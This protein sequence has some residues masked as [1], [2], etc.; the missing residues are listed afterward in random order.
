MVSFNHD[1]VPDYLRTKP[2][3]EVEEKITQHTI[4]GNSIQP[5]VF[6]VAQVKFCLLVIFSCNKIFLNSFLVIKFC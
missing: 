4:K 3:P 2:E 1:V 6:Q 5:E